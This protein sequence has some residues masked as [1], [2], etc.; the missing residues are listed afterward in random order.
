MTAPAVAGSAGTTHRYRTSDV[1]SDASSFAD[2]LL[3][4]PLVKA[5]AAAGFVRP[6]PVQRLAIPL[7]C[8]GGDL[9][10]QAKSGTGKTCVFAVIALRRVDATAPLPQAL[11]LAPTREVALQ[12]ADVVRRIAA[13][14]PAPAP[15][16]LA[17]VGGL[18]VAD[19]Q[20]RLRRA[21]HIAVGTPGRVCALLASGALPARALRLLVLDEADALLGEGFRGD[22]AWAH[23]QLP[24]RKQV[25]AFSATYAPGLL[26]DLEPLTRR[27]QKVL[28]CEETV[29]LRGVRQFYRLVDDAD[30]GGGGGDGDG[31]GG[32]AD[33]GSVDGGDKASISSTQPANAADAD[34]ALQRVLSAKADAILRLLG[35]AS[36]HQ[37]VVFCNRK[38]A[39]EWLARRLSAAGF[40]A[41][42]LSADLPQLERNAVVA[43]LRAFKLRAVVAT[44][45]MAR[46]VDLERAN[47]VALADVP[48]DAATYVHRVGRTGRFGTRG[49]SVAFVTRAELRQLKALVAEARGGEQRGAQGLQGW[50][51]RNHTTTSSPLSHVPNRFSNLHA[52]LQRSR[53][54]ALLA[55]PPPPT[56]MGHPLKTQATSSRCP[57]PSPPTSTRLSCGRTGSAPRCASCRRRRWARRR[58]AR[59]PYGGETASG[60]RQPTTAR[61]AA[62][63]TARLTRPTAGTPPRARGG[64]RAR[65]APGSRWRRRRATSA[66][67]VVAAAAAAAAT[68]ATR[69]TRS[70]GRRGSTGNSGRPTT[71]AAATAAAARPW[72]SRTGSSGLT[73]A[74]SSNSSKS[75]P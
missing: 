33:G 38:P 13:A 63:G 75:R 49:V 44:D 58:P 68:R 24:A 53:F 51:P 52:C 7:G 57:P 26:A 47:L 62:T 15:E 27:P 16:C 41:A 1:E 6:S 9:L 39:A 66:A 35:A 18:P 54:H 28:L 31:E 46:G 55:S 69:A 42:P 11:V 8:V 3:P 45:V 20:K 64:A 12:S 73:V 67:A 40:P 22:V 23:A 32:D 17:F 56:L 34:A 25:L 50:A 61:P 71:A 2:L 59:R 60:S 65:S 10:V 19:D 74:S 29:S 48:P 21:C 43:A 72:C 36:F 4:P 14:L 30:F 5:L 37:A 70:S